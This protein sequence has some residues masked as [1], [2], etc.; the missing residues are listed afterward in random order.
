MQKPLSV[1]IPSKWKVKLPNGA[2]VQ[3]IGICENPSAG[4]Q[5]W[6]PDGT[7]TDYVPYINTEA[8]GPSRDDRKIYEMVWSVRF[9]KIPDGSNGGGT[10]TSLEGSMGSYGRSVRD[11]YGNRVQGNFSTGGYS[12]KNSRRK[13]TWKI[14]VKV[15]DG[16]YERVKFENISLVPG[17][18]QGFI[19]KIEKK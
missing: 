14:G 9:P 4:K 13:T 12:F 2:T 10:T 11:K 15:G 7:P 8:Y 6:G 17:E 16:E 5:W 19:I 18:N 3:F 1:A